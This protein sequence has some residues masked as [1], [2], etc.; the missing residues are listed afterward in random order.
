MTSSSRHR[1]EH[2]D[3]V[4]LLAL[5]WR[6]KLLDAFVGI[7]TDGFP[8]SVARIVPLSFHLRAVELVHVNADWLAARRVGDDEASVFGSRRYEA[9]WAAARLR[10]EDRLVGNHLVPWP[11]LE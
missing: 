6:D 1:I 10:R 11:L 8:R 7:L 3:P 2:Q 5:R 4:A 9:V